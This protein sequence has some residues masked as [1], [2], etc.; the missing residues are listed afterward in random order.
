[1]NKFVVLGLS[2]L[3]AFNVHAQ[4]VEGSASGASAGTIGGIATGTIV[5]GAIAAGVL[6]AVVSNNRSDSAPIT[7][8]KPPVKKACNPGDGDPVNDVCTGTTTTVTV[9]GSGTG[10]ATTTITVPVTFTYAA[11]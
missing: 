6:A 9:T 4:D 3:L 10:T 1:M 11:K 8:I 2:T 7:P 5:A